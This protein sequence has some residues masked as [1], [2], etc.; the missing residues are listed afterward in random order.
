MIKASFIL[1]IYK[2]FLS[3]FV[4]VLIKVSAPFLWMTYT[5]K[6]RDQ[7]KIL[8]FPVKVDSVAQQ[9]EQ[10][11]TA[12]PKQG[13]NFPLTS[14]GHALKNNDRRRSQD[15]ASEYILKEIYFTPQNEKKGVGN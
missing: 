10:H 7:L 1:F 2:Q 12:L 13:P 11:H 14:S 9:R 8:G 6:K 15:V 4:F 5:L 3:R